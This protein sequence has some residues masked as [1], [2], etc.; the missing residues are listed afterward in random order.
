MVSW[1]NK[2]RSRIGLFSVSKI[3]DVKG[4]LAQ[5]HPKR[6]KSARIV[7]WVGSLVGKIFSAD[8]I[9]SYCGS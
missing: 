9:S 7:V 5:M 2:G 6:R 1:R 8:V 4:L 3:N